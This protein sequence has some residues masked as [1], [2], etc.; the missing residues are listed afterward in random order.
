[1]VIEHAGTK[2]KV[3][4]FYSVRDSCVLTNGYIEFHEKHKELVDAVVQ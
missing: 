2:Y 4:L 3:C 1:M